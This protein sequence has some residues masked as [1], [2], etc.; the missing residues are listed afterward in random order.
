MEESEQLNQPREWGRLSVEE[1]QAHRQLNCLWYNNCLTKA[2]IHGW[3]G[4]TCFWC[5][6]KGG[7]DGLDRGN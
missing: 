7:K 6:M 3:S 4:F 1:V 2:A 5:K